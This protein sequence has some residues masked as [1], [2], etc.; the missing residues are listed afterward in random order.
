MMNLIL[1]I[2]MAIKLCTEFF[3]CI[4][5]QGSF[6]EIS[7]EYWTIRGQYWKADEVG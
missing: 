6:H 3:K 4:S 5:I 7:A 2:T 1:T